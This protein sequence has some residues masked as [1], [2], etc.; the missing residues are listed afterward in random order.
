MLTVTE[1]ANPTNQFH[2]K[3]AKNTQK[4]SAILPWSFRGRSTR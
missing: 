4:T 1:P 3:C 2:G